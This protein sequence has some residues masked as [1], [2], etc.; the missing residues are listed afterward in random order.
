MRGEAVIAVGPPTTGT[1][2]DFA[3]QINPTDRAAAQGAITKITSLLEQ[4]LGIKLDQR[5][6][7][8]G[9]TM[10][11]FPAAIRQ[12]IQP[13][14]ALLSDRFILA[15]S[16]DYLTALAKG[17]GGFDSSSAFKDTLGSSKSGSQFQMVLQL[18]SIR[19]Y[20]E[21][22]LTGANKT[23][24]EQDVKPWVD[25]LSATGLRVYKDGK[26]TRFESK[27]TVD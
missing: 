17:S 11:V 6:A 7:P 18:S 26:Y 10:Y 13:A 9:G 12:G 23:R 21:G 24:Y 16:P 27:A 14:M 19:K 2:P 4:R 25:H 15:S 1:T 20:V 5:P 22:L 8:G 3:L